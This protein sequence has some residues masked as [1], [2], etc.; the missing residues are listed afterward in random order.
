MS[1]TLETSC[2]DRFLI[3]K[4]M[5]STMPCHVCKSGPI[6][7]TEAIKLVTYGK[8][9]DLLDLSAFEN[10][11]QEELIQLFSKDAVKTIEFKSDTLRYVIELFF[12]RGYALNIFYVAIP[13]LNKLLSTASKHNVKLSQT[14]TAELTDLKTVS[15]TFEQLSGL[16]LILCANKLC[17]AEFTTQEGKTVIHGV[18][19]DT[20]KTL[21]DY[22]KFT[23]LLD[24]LKL[25]DVLNGKTT[26]E[27]YVGTLDYTLFSNDIPYLLE[28][29]AQRSTNVNFAQHKLAGIIKALN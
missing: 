14:D 5:Q 28:L 1:M 11:T 27:Q 7:T 22:R 8:V 21:T 26:I 17:H 3:F 20:P 23:R 13:L 15:L 9:W 18:A 6:D 19:I 16:A 10:L 4:L 2:E 25:T 24:A 12:M 29:V